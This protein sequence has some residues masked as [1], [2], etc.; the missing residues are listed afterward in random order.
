MDLPLACRILVVLR[1][2]QAGLCRFQDLTLVEGTRRKIGKNEN[3]F[4]R[5]GNCSTPMPG[6]YCCLE[7]MNA[8]VGVEVLNNLL[9]N[10]G[11]GG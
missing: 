5:T 2:S 3:V 6:V 7:D 11:S 1:V 4:P 10:F 9:S 8:T